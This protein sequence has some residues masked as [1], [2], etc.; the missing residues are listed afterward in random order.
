LVKALS[1]RQV[2]LVAFTASAAWALFFLVDPAT[3]LFLPP[4]PFH[5]LTGYYCPICGSTRALHQ[6]AHGNV[7]QAL[8]LN[9]LLVFGLLLGGLTSVYRV[10]GEVPGWCLRILISVIVL[11]GIVRNIPVFPC[12]LLAP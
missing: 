5:L 10:Q 4:C 3:R 2:V 12:T 6:L 1:A 8:R 7:L 11:F 9:A